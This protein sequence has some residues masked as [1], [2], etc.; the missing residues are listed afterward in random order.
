[1]VQ[2]FGG[3]AIRPQG[4]GIMVRGVTGDQRVQLGEEV[5]GQRFGWSW[6]WSLRLSRG[7]MHSKLI[8]PSSEGVKFIFKQYTLNI[9][10]FIVHRQ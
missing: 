5:R 6:N 10:S 8:H 2:D 4:V 3:Q 9:G 1:M 7:C